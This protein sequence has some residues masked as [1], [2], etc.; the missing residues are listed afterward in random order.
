MPHG[1]DLVAFLTTLIW[2][3]P[4]F[5]MLSLTWGAVDAALK[6]ETLGH[7]NK[8]AF[9]LLYSVFLTPSH[10]DFQCL[11]S[12]YSLLQTFSQLQVGNRIRCKKMAWNVKSRE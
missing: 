7:L 2:A 3:L 11:E 6:A 9:L 4:G 12:L 10:L 1:T 5:S 8:V